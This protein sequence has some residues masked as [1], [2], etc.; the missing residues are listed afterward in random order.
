MES[1]GFFTSKLVD[2]NW[3]RTYVAEQFAQY[4][5][6]F[7]SN[8]VFMNLNSSSLM[9]ESLSDEGMK[10][11][12]NAGEGF[13]NGYW[14]NNDSLLKKDITPADGIL[15][16]IDLIVARYD[17]EKRVISSVVIEGAPSQTPVEPE[18]L[19]NADFY[20]LVLARIEIPAGATK[21]S[22][23]QITDLRLDSNYCGSVGALVEQID[24]SEYGS[25]LNNF[26]ADYIKKSNTTFESFE[27]SL[28]VMLNNYKELTAKF[29]SEAEEEFEA[30]FENIKS[31][32]SE[33]A[34]GSLQLQIDHTNTK[35]DLLEIQ[36]S[37]DYT[38]SNSI[39]GKLQIIEINGNSEQNGI[40]TPDTPIEI[41]SVGTYDETSGK[42]IAS[43]N[44][45]NVEKSKNL[46]DCSGLV[47]TTN[48]GVTFT[49]VYNE[50]GGLEYIEVNGTNDAGRPLSYGFHVERPEYGDYIFSG[51]PKGGSSSTYSWG[52]SHLTDNVP[53]ASEYG[54]GASVEVGNYVSGSGERR[55][56]IMIS[57]YLNYTADHLRFYPMLRKVGIEDST[58]EPY[59]PY[60]DYTKHI[61]LDEPLRKVRG[62]ADRIINKDGVWGVERNI[63]EIGSYSS[64]TI[65]T[66]YIST[67]GEL[68]EGATIQ[69]ILVEST[70]EPFDIETQEVFYTLETYDSATYISIDSAVKPSTIKVEYGASKVGAYALKSLQDVEILRNELNSLEDKLNNIVNG[71]EVLY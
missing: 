48:G 59:R 70:F 52:I 42:Y 20:D 43:I 39:K 14:Y 29:Q 3:D 60:T 2:G 7:I 53:S 32:W 15:N 41:K 9:V 46:L 71:N 38:L 16:R 13:I 22:S 61:Y 62:V 12:I 18:Y 1:S 24:T 50:N 21:I 63:G 34:A 57:I 67:T 19:R 30:W 23:S 35:L 6:R 54:D 8:G 66:D 26:I 28:M 64:E 51:C 36:Q 68:S 55:L 49:P 44:V 58:Y 47:E 45:C 11:A 65:S 5:A 17:N 4:F 37:T 56:Y 40:P 31:R 27:N 69:Y 33:D 25:Q 10:I